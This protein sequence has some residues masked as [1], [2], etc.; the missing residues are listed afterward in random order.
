MSCTGDKNYAVFEQVGRRL[1]V[2]HGLD[3]K[4]RWLKA[5]ET[6]LVPDS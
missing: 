6:G 4:V 5:Q 1:I 2:S 3:E